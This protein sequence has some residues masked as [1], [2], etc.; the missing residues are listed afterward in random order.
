[1]RHANT[2]EW[3]GVRAGA[4]LLR[5]I[6]VLLVV[7]IGT[8][9]FEGHCDPYEHHCEGIPRRGAIEKKLLSMPG[10]HLVMV[11]YHP[12]HDPNFEW[13]YNGAEIDGAKMLWA[14]ELDKE[15]NT[16]LL[17]YFKDR[18]IWIVD[19]DDDDSELTPYTGP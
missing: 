8:S 15:Q 14:R 2:V 13:V 11:H 12:D 9:A 7:E 16:K 4:I 5:L 18:K 10:K 19:A 3:R 17:A 1:M 6:F